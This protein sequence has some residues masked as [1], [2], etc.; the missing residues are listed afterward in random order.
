V[1]NNDVPTAATPTP[2]RNLANYFLGVPLASL[3]ALISPTTGGT[4]YR[5]TYTQTWN[6]NLQHQFGS[7][8]AAEV[9][10]VGNKGT[11][12]SN[13]SVYN[14]PL[15]GPGNVDARR[16]YLQWGAIRYLTWGGS[17]IYHSLQAKVE[18]RFSKGVSFLGSYSFSRCLDGPGSEEGGAPA[19]YLEPI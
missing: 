4:R 10:Y 5:S 7:G 13:T 19:A 15:P 11:R 14:V 1:L 3:D 12:T 16:P 9:A 2:R 18:K 8:I 17:S 6:L